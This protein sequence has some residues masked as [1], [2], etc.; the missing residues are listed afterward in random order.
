VSETDTSGKGIDGKASKAWVGARHKHGHDKAQHRA[1]QSS[2]QPTSGRLL[3]VSQPS[4]ETASQPGPGARSSV[5]SRAAPFWVAL[6][7]GSP[8]RRPRR[9]GPAALVLAAAAGSR[10]LAGD[11]PQQRSRSPSKSPAGCVSGCGCSRLP[12]RPEH[13]PR[14]AILPR[15]RAPSSRLARHSV[16]A[17]SR[18]HSHRVRRSYSQPVGHRRQLQGGW[19]FYFLTQRPAIPASPGREGTCVCPTI[20]LNLCAPAS[21][22]SALS[23]E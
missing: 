18:F 3:A 22:K 11:R 14:D 1:A 23:P 19:Q 17:S 4:I 15:N 8:R 10:S 5:G 21:R 13:G 20:V 12:M 6:L 2:S 9:S 7:A 16:T